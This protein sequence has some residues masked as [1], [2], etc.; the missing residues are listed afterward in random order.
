MELL[1]L[2]LACGAGAFLIHWCTE[3]RPSVISGTVVDWTTGRPVAG[4]VLRFKEINGSREAT[5]AD[6]EGRFT[7]IAAE[8]DQLYVLYA[9]DPT[10]GPVLQ[11][12][13]GRSVVVYTR[14]QRH[15]G[16]TV[17]ALPATELSGHVYD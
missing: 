1:L 16:L 8:A 13:F 4:A 10:F 11:T 17:P 15:S 12:A 14:G 7:A 9:A 2:L 6:A 3:S 5:T